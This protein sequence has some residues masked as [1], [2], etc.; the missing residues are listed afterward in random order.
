VGVARVVLP[1]V[2]STNAE[3]T[4]RAPGPLWVLGLEQTAGRGR[5]ARAWA[6]PRG[7]F[8]A[9]LVMQPAGAAGQV[10]LRSFVASLAL[11]DALIAVTG[12]PQAFA[13]KWPN[14]VLCNGGKIAGILL[15]STTAGAGVAHLVVGVGVNLIA[16][17]DQAMIEGGAVPP[18]TLLA[19]TGKRVEPEAFL[20]ALAPAF[21]L[22]EAQ[23][24]TQG[25]AS[26]RAD[27]LAHAA[28]IGQPIRA[29]TGRET[30]HGTYD[31]IDETGALILTTAAG[32]LAI[33]AA[34]VFF[35]P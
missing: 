10:A 13:L 26:I 27:W 5:R 25:F 28:N 32:R 34:D 12:L 8:H 6:S 14:D 30:H 3:A 2:G 22:R 17:P 11:R 33:P 20:D 9:S 29:R 16:V 1:V 7:N 24:M 15:E 31:T 18:V 19:E 4:A 23:L 35:D 21:A